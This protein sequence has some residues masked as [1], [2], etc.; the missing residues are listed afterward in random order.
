MQ[1]L[2]GYRHTHSEL[3]RAIAELSAMLDA[4]QW[5]RHPQTRHAYEALC[6]LGERVR[7]HLADEHRRL[8]PT[9]LMHDDPDASSV[10]WRF[11]S[12]ELPLRQSFDRYYERWLKYCDHDFGDDFG[13]D[14]FLAETRE[15]FDLVAQRIE[16]EEQVLI[17][18]LLE[19]GLLGR[20]PMSGD[21][22]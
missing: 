4:E 16:R 21:S 9:L 2:D 17:P 18:K 20:A 6:E 11:L 7:L 1:I 12:S 5:R 8:Y 22:A 3:R 13:N 15:V 19:V 10:A 14:D